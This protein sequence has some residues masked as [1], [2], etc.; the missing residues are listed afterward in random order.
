MRVQRGD[1]AQR[2]LERMRRQD[3]E[4]REH[5]ELKTIESSRALGMVVGGTAGW[6]A[7]AELAPMIADSLGMEGG[8]TALKVIGAGLGALGGAGAGTWLSAR[9]QGKQLSTESVWTYSRMASAAVGGVGGWALAK[10]LA[11]L[12][13]AGEILTGIGA[14]VVLMKG[15]D[16]A[17]KA[18]LRRQI[19]AVDGL[20]GEDRK[21]IKKVAREKGFPGTDLRPALNAGLV[22]VVGTVLAT[23]AMHGDV[24]LGLGLLGATGVAALATYKV[25]EGFKEVN[26]RVKDRA[27][28]HM[29]VNRLL[30]EEADKAELKARTSVLER[31]RAIEARYQDQQLPQPLREELTRQSGALKA[32]GNLEQQ[33]EAVRRLEGCFEHAQKIQP[34]SQSKEFQRTRS[35]VADDIHQ[36]QTMAGLYNTMRQKF[37]DF[38][39][40]LPADLAAKP[41]YEEFQAVRYDASVEQ[42]Q[43][44]VEATKDADELDGLIHFEEDEI[45][46]GSFALEVD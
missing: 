21:W 8:S 24:T 29:I 22:G 16:L 46:I 25:T 9:A 1:H 34:Q 7:A 20:T 27:T 14:G 42:V 36:Y 13:P 35:A 33:L 12:S 17:F 39:G 11:D 45:Q 10:A 37:V 5:A 43:R 3:Q 41:L 15:V 32:A 28:T 4:R 40:E 31:G 30:Q 6:M 2:Y 38:V 18:H 23:T 19:E 44:L 26:P